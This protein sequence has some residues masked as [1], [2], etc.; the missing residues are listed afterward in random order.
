[1]GKKIEMVEPTL[2]EMNDYLDWRIAILEQ[3]IID[4][5]KFPMPLAARTILREALKRD[6]PNKPAKRK[7]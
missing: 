1:M 7:R 3:A 6:D 4:A 2:E 5:D